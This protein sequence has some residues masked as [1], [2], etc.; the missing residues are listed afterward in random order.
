MLVRRRMYQPRPISKAL[1]F[2][3]LNVS[4]LWTWTVGKQSLSM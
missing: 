3:D 2:S 4:S 1:P